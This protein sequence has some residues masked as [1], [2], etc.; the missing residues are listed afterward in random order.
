MG[1]YFYTPIKIGGEIVE[2]YS[3]G[4]ISGNRLNYLVDIP[5][6]SQNNLI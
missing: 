2:S 3:R 4:S 5:L 1:V 6:K